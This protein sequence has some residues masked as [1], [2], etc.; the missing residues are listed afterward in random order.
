MAKKTI[1]KS[2]V[3]ETGTTIAEPEQ[4]LGLTETSYPKDADIIPTVNEVSIP[5]K[6]QKKIKRK[7]QIR[8]ELKPKS[9]I[10]TKPALKISEKRIM[11]QSL[12]R[13]I[14]RNQPLL[15]KIL[16]FFID[17]NVLYNTVYQKLSYGFEISEDRNIVTVNIS[18]E[19][20]NVNP[21]LYDE[22]K[23]TIKDIRVSP[24]S[25]SIKGID[26]S[27]ETKVFEK[28]KSKPKATR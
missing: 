23:N 11:S 22:L 26:V 1:N 8:T 28:L 25:T 24:R 21:G 5:K 27:V 19:K 9:K 13:T 18:F 6:V 17:K 20:D 14:Q 10:E 7:P 3:L 16:R 12:L 4:P 2:K 15:H